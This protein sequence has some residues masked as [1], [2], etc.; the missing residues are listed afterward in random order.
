MNHVEA[1]AEAEV[2]DVGEDEEE[3]EDGEKGLM[4]KEKTWKLSREMRR[5]Q[6]ISCPISM[7]KG[8]PMKEGE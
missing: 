1:E 8:M 2:E 3:V 5:S 4:M 6:T 7:L